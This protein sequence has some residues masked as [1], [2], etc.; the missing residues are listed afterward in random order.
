MIA[1]I[2]ALFDAPDI[3]AAARA[4]SQ[5]YE[6]QPRRADARTQPRAV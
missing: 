1:V 4:L 6:S 3:E 5:L 2:A